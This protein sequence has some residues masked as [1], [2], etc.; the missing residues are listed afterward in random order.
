[1]SVRLDSDSDSPSSSENEGEEGDAHVQR[2]SPARSC[3]HSEQQ[4]TPSAHQRKC[5]DTSR[6]R[7]STCE[8]PTI[9]ANRESAGATSSDALEP[10]RSGTKNTSSSDARSGSCNAV[11]SSARSLLK[12]NK[13]SNEP[14]TSASHSL[15]EESDDPIEDSDCGA[16]KYIRLGQGER[17]WVLQRSIAAK[18]YEHQRD[19]VRWL[20]GLH[21]KGSG[22]ILGDDMGLGKTLSV[23]AFLAGLLVGRCI[24]AAIV[25]APAT[26]LGQWEKELSLCQCSGIVHRLHGQS[27]RQRESKIR[28]VRERGG[29]VLTTYGMLTHNMDLFC[30]SEGEL[31]SEAGRGW[32]GAGSAGNAQDSRDG[33]GSLAFEWLIAGSFKFCK[34][35]LISLCIFVDH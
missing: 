3:T 28:T 2:S 23:S 13:S 31:S 18:L 8:A 6:A 12:P 16:V 30:A 19:A 1:M 26:L 32:S 29:I 22:G 11:D 15:Y 27:Q 4:F 35:M 24:S 17:K 20:W 25:I 14:S 34:L 7:S 10:R 9:P 21:K 33:D 5:S